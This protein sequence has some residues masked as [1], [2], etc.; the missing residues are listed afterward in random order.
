MWDGKNS[1]Y[2]LVK[3]VFVSYLDVKSAIEMAPIIAAI[4]S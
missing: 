2:V 4:V 1:E 3:D